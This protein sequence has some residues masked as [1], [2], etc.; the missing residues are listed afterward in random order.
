MFK[1]PNWKQLLCV[2]VFSVISALLRHSEV[3]TAKW[4][5]WVIAFAFVAVYEVLS[6]KEKQKEDDEGDMPAK[7]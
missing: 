7:D 2:V 5:W 1:L 4:I 6:T 3:I